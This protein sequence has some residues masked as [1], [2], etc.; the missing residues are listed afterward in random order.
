MPRV[1]KDELGS[2]LKN[3]KKETSDSLQR[4]F[5]RPYDGFWEFQK[6]MDSDFYNET[7]KDLKLIAFAFY[8]LAWSHIHKCAVNAPRRIGKSHSVNDLIKYEIGYRSEESNARYSYSGDLVKK[9]SKFIRRAIQ[10]K[11]YLIVF[12]DIKL[13]SDSKGIFQWEITL[14]KGESTFSC[15]G[16]DGK[17]T[18]DGVSN[19][20]IGDDTIKGMKE[21]N[22]VSEKLN[23]AEFRSANFKGSKQGDMR[24][25]ETATTWTDDDPI[26]KEL[27]TAK[28]M[29][30]RIFKFD[31]YKTKLNDE[32][33]ISFIDSI[34]KAKP[35]KYDW[36]HITIPSLDKDDESTS[37]T[38]AEHST[39]DLKHKREELKALGQEYLWYSV[40]QQDVRPRG[41]MMFKDFKNYFYYSDLE[42]L[43]FSS[44]VMFLDPAGKGSN[45][46]CCP[47]GR[48][49]GNKV[50]IVDV[51]YNPEEPKITKPMIVSFILKYSEHI[52]M[53]SGEGNGLG[54]QYIESVNDM[55]VEKGSN[56]AFDY[57]I[58]T[59]NKEE[60]IFF[61]SDWIK[62]NVW[63]PAEY[64][65]K[66]KRQ[67]EIDSPMDR[68]I[69]SLTKYVGKV[70]GMFVRNQEDDFPDALC[71]IKV[72]IAEEGVAFDFGF[73]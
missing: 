22:S 73:Y 39:E 13:R 10:S 48:L 72:M 7:R 31:A 17:S 45:N 43:N 61:N 65:K 47:F 11:E 41:A 40:D 51:V 15:A 27:L 69:K 20:L 30:H 21:A 8:L 12:P 56:L 34:I 2:I 46:T 4:R 53:M 59:D 35:I 60:K 38:L 64:D 14:C 36:I 50:Y 26:P 23:L 54:D 63:I 62:A 66:G 19:I 49:A 6:Y 57:E 25:L 58:T 52:S 55:L 3:I 16:I 67:Y 1:E 42:K 32:N 33:I 18:G 28:K 29:G 37:P 68:S 44:G 9:H 5:E 24:Q 71:G 70:Q